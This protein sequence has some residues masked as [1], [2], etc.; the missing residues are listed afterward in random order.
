[1]SHEYSSDI[2]EKYPLVLPLQRYEEV[3]W[4]NPG[5][6]PV[7][8]GLSGVEVTMQ[9]VENARLRMEKF[10]GYI[11]DNFPDTAS[12]GGIIESAIEPLKNMQN[13]MNKKFGREMP[14]HIFLKMDSH[15]PIAG[16]IKAR[17]GIYEILSHAESLALGSGILSESDDYRI[18]STRKFRDFFSAH[19]IAVAST[20]NLGL[21][22]GIIGRALGFE[23]NV[24]MSE[25][26]TAWKKTLLVERGVNII[27]HSGDY[28]SAVAES[29]RLSGDIPSS[30]FVDDEN[31]RLLFLGYAVAGLRLK[32][33]LTQLGHLVDERHP[34]FVY[35]PC[36]VG[37]APGGVTLGLKLAFGDHVRCFW[38]EPTHSPS[39]LLGMHTG[40]H[41][42]ICVSD[43]GVDNKTGASGLAVGRPSGFVGQMMSHLLDGIY[44]VNDQVLYDL[45][46]SLYETENIFLEPSAL[47]GM[48]GPYRA[49]DAGVFENR[50]RPLDQHDTVPLHLI[51]GTGGGMVPKPVMLEY[52]SGSR[53]I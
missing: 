3:F 35:L 30:Y 20:G 12:K 18:F 13:H 4:K 7:G 17:G 42:D 26:A 10:S 5:R 40:L 33:Q 34:L 21:A 53:E 37:G 52:L 19:S 51:W 49:L 8:N 41:H 29:R 23:V 27:E 43:I 48:V 22:I 31:S 9:D 45:L 50:E 39:M 38:A 46:I 36:G 1:M 28:S 14:G 44:T 24:H 32:E 11:L 47:A 6:V 15:L 16:S 25:E 2:G